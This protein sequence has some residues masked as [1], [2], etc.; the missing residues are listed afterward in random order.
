MR[1][2]HTRF[3]LIRKK[4]NDVKYMTDYPQE[5]S[6]IYHSK[7]GQKPAQQWKLTGEIERVG[8]FVYDDDG[9][10]KSHSELKH[11]CFSLSFV[12]DSSRLKRERKLN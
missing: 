12:A 10:K 11:L 2:T 6:G 7:E 1:N 9:R 4:T 8:K 5:M 3:E